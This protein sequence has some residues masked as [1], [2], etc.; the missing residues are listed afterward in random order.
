MQDHLCNV[1]FFYRVC[2]DNSKISAFHRCLPNNC[3]LCAVVATITSHMTTVII[4]QASLRKVLNLL[5]LKSK[6]YGALFEFKI[7]VHVPPYSFL[8]AAVK[9]LFG[10][11]ILL[12]QNFYSAI[13]FW[14]AYSN[15]FWYFLHCNHHTDVVNKESHISFHK[16]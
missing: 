13:N 6:D 3:Y 15:G 12:D 11:V 1:S 7:T 4:N 8:F 14:P 9:T 5:L 2:D 10:I 16:S